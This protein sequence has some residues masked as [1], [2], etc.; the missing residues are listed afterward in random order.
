MVRCWALSLKERPSFTDIV[1][2]LGELPSDSKV[3]SDQSSHSRKELLPTLPRPPSPKIQTGMLDYLVSHISGKRVEGEEKRKKKTLIFY[4]FQQFFECGLD[5]FAIW[6]ELHS[7]FVWMASCEQC[8]EFAFTAVWTILPHLQPPPVVPLWPRPSA[9]VFVSRS[10]T[11]S[12]PLPLHTHSH[13]L[14]KFV[15]MMVHSLALISAKDLPE[16]SRHHLTPWSFLINLKR[17]LKRKWGTV[18][19]QWS[20]EA[21]VDNQPLY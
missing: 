9:A 12:V 11:T 2:A 15:G 6:V 18:G 19:L 10:L 8:Q 20:D 5:L 1:H 7:P 13:T 17:I 3:W 21:S 14:S 4:A 16:M